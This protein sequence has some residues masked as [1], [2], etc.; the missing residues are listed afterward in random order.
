[1]GEGT[2]SE[3][4]RLRREE[5]CRLGWIYWYNFTYSEFKQIL[6]AELD[7][8]YVIGWYM[9]SELNGASSEIKFI[10]QKFFSVL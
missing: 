3:S 7:S 10:C 4:L 9:R 6:T 2:D 5:I 1:M 8:N